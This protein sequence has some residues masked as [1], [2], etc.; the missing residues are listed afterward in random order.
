MP[1]WRRPMDEA[2]MGRAP[3]G[4]CASTSRGT[5]YGTQSQYGVP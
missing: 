2:A 1:A 5:P 3:G 4:A